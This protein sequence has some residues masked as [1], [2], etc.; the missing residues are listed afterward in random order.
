LDPI[1]TLQIFLSSLLA[2][3]SIAVLVVAYLMAEY[4]KAKENNWKTIS[5]RYYFI[6]WIMIAVLIIGGVEGAVITLFVSNW[7]PV[8]EYQSVLD[9]ATIPFLLVILTVP[10]SLLY[11]WKREVK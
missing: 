4:S 9:Y 1:E 5:R 2:L 7:I 10:F 6:I 8:T 3:E 11:M